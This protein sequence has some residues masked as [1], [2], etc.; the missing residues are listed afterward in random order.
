MKA[1][2]CDY[3]SIDEEYF[4]LVDYVQANKETFDTIDE[5]ARRKLIEEFLSAQ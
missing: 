2:R 1:V 3:S 4:P 5:A